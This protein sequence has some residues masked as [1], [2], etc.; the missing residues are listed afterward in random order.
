ME[1]TKNTN[2]NEGIRSRTTVFYDE[3][4]PNAEVLAMILTHKNHTIV[5]SWGKDCYDVGYSTLIGNGHVLH[6]SHLRSNYKSYASKT[7]WKYPEKEVFAARTEY[8]WEDLG[9]LNLALG[10]T[11]NLTEYAR[12]KETHGS[13]S[14]KVK[15]KLSKVGRATFCCHLHDE[16]EIYEQLILSSVN[17]PMREK[18][19]TLN[20]LY[21]DCGI[22]L[23]QYQN[24][25]FSWK[26]WAQSRCGL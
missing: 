12:L 3:C 10:G 20:V 5:N 8:L 18:Q 26:E 17:L 1:H 19:K 6:A 25:S 2:A 13:E 9:A 15:S 11:S 21:E 14:Y 4:F 7:S 23:N 24:S 16:N 22:P